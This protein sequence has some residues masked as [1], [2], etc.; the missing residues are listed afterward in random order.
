VAHGIA[1][2]IPFL[3]RVHRL[4]LAQPAVRSLL[5]G[6]V[7]W[8]L[9]HLVDIVT[10]PEF[11]AAL[12]VASPSLAAAVDPWRKEPDSDR[13]RATERSL[14]SY[15]LRAAALPTPFGLF[16][17]C[18]TGI[19]GER[20]RLRLEGPARYRRR[21]RLDMDYLWALADAVRIDAYLARRPDLA[22]ATGRPG[23]HGPARAARAART[24]P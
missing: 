16:A 23:R 20:T 21:T 13:S 5:D 22:G 2:V 10:T 7:N 4:G 18:T 17:G 9:A 8:L 12:F 6:C 19:T 24:R 14:V 1:G 3:A 11:R 15:L